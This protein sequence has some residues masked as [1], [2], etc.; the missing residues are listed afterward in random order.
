MWKIL[1]KRKKNNIMTEDQIEKIIGL[2]E[3]MRDL[4]KILASPASVEGPS[5]QEKRHARAVKDWGMHLEEK[6]PKN[7]YERIAMVVDF[8]GKEVN[9]KDIIDFIRENPDSFV[10]LNEETL[11]GVIRNTA[12]HKHYGY[13]EFADKKEKN[14][15][16]LSIKGRHLISTLPN[17]PKVKKASKKSS[18]KRPQE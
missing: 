16:R 18:A 4:L 8:L 10:N 15:Y 13:I 11:K 14:Y 9:S 17:R 6:K 2:L 1:R 5:H 7:D 3:E 12:T